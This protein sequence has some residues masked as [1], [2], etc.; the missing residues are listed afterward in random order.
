M[1]DLPYEL[2]EGPGV[3]QIHGDGNKILMFDDWNFLE[4]TISNEGYEYRQVLWGHWLN[5]YPRNAFAI[6]LVPPSSKLTC[7]ENE[8]MLIGAGRK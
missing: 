4:M 1:P 3:Y 5:D 2:D 7:E 8:P 6:V